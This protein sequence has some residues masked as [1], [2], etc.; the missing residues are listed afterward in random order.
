MKDAET[1]LTPLEEDCTGDV[2]RMLFEAVG[3]LR[4]ALESGLKDQ[5][6]IN[7]T[8][9]NVLLHLAEQEDGSMRLGDLARTLIFSPSRLSYQIRSLEKRGLL[10]RQRSAEDGRGA[11]AVI[12]D[13]GRQVLRD[14]EQTYSRVV[15]ILLCELVNKEEARVLHRVLKRLNQSL[16]INTLTSLARL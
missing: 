7:L 10:E 1:E 8:E 2:D 4:L 9:Y 15:S 11:H 14:C 5:G 13:A 16:S 12:T 6:N 3:R